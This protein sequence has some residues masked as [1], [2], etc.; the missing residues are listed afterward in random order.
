MKP[1]EHSAAVATR[2]VKCPN[3]GEPALYAA[4][5]PYRPFCGERCKQ[6]DIGAWAMER[7][8]VPTEAPPEDSSFGDPRLQ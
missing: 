4:S 3:C 2:L 8:R 1:S 7:F 5:N 6:I